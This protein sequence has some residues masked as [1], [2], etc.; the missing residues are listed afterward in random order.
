MSIP[1]TNYY[2]P[3]NITRASHVVLNVKDLQ[4]SKAHYVDMLGMVMTEMTNDALYLRGIDER[5]HH[6]V[7]LQKSDEPGTVGRLGLR[8]FMDEDLDKAYAWFND[9]GT[10]CR[11]ADVP[12]QG[13]TLHFEDPAGMP[14]ELCARMTQVQSLHDKFYL[15]T[16][17][18]PR[19]LDHF[20]MAC[21]NVEKVTAFY[22]N[23]GFRLS[24][25]TDSDDG[26]EMWGTWLQRKGNP[27][28]IVFTNG[29][30]PSLHHFAMQAKDASTIMHI[31]DVVGSMGLEDIIDRQPSRHGIGNAMFVYFRDPDGHRMEYYDAHYPMIDI[32]HEPMRWPLSNTKR[33]S[34]WGVPASRRW[35]FQTSP[36]AGV[37]LN[38][39]TLKGEPMTLERWVAEKEKI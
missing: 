2:P 25:Y 10:P 35:Y 26:S 27:H 6:S 39:P 20:Q 22:T 34:I 19:V 37:P 11:W 24:E 18:H 15:H 14:V 33:S 12:F 29:R 9:N 21:H 4:A 5:S 28:D 38:E 31:T 1:P 32:D 23:L 17:G 13:K 30:G 8:V 7:V 3:F 16:G 36:F